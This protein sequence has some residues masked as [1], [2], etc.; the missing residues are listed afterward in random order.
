MFASDKCKLLPTFNALF[1]ECNLAYDWDYED[2]EYYEEGW[3]PMPSNTSTEEMDPTPWTYQTQ[4]KLKGTPYWGHFATYLGGG[5]SFTV[6]MARLKRI[7][8]FAERSSVKAD[9]H[10]ITPKSI[11]GS[12]QLMVS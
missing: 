11:L 4:W 5:E 10:A 1:D 7:Q 9:V 2:K 3:V 6:D 8:L 12:F